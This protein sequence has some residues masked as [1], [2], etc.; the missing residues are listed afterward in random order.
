MSDWWTAVPESVRKVPLTD[1]QRA[2]LEA[3]V[4]YARGYPEVRGMRQQD[5]ADRLSCSEMTVRRR[6][7]GLKRAG[8]VTTRWAST[9]DVVTLSWVAPVSG[10][11]TV[12]RGPDRP[13]DGGGE[14]RHVAPKKTEQGRRREEDE[15]KKHEPGK[16][17]PGS[18]TSRV[19]EA[20][21]V[22]AG[23][24]SADSP[25]ALARF[26]E[27]E[28]RRLQPKLEWTPN[29]PALAS[30]FRRWLEGGLLPDEIREM[31]T[32]FVRAELNR[33]TAFDARP[34]WVRQRSRSEAARVATPAGG[35]AWAGYDAR[36]D[37]N[38]PWKFFLAARQRLLGELRAVQLAA[39]PG[40]AFR[41]DATTGDD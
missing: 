27:G 35:L 32:S 17:R 14:H 41:S 8:L 36:T 31:I 16:P 21:D 9:G 24:R 15:E 40:R 6:L 10:M 1:G 5:W 29:A 38:W 22:P 33:E 13:S 4:E 25:S 37:P 30:N 39:D 3:I 34:G 26:F 2:L 11:N 12:P 20:S 7:A 18:S 28:M 23:R 19:A